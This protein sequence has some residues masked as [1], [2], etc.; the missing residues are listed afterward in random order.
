M[1][2]IQ[3][4]RFMKRLIDELKLTMIVLLAVLLLFSTVQVKPILAYTQNED[5]FEE[6]V[7]AELSTDDDVKINEELL[8]SEDTLNTELL[9]PEQEPGTTEAE[10]SGALESD[11]IEEATPHVSFDENRLE[12]RVGGVAPGFVNVDDLATPNHIAWP[13]N[14]QQRQLQ[15][16]AEFSELGIPKAREI[17]VIVPEGYRILE[18]TAM[19][20]TNAGAGVN[21]LF[22]EAEDNSKFESS[23]LSAIDG[24]SWV[25]QGIDGY[26]GTTAA[27]VNSGIVRERT[28]N[29]QISYVFNSNADHITLTLTLGTHHQVMPRPATDLLLSPIEVTMTSGGQTLRSSLSSTVSPLSVFTLSNVGLQSG[30]RPVSIDEHGNTGIFSTHFTG[31]LH[32]GTLGTQTALTSGVTLTFSYPEGVHFIGFSEMLTH[33]PQ[34]YATTFSNAHL[35]VT[36]DPINRVV[37]FTYS[38]VRTRH[39][40]HSN[41]FVL[42]WEAHV[43]G[44]VLTEGVNHPFGARATSDFRDGSSFTHDF[45]QNVR[46]ELDRSDLQIIPRNFVREDLNRYGDFPYSYMLG[47]FNVNLVGNTPTPPLFYR[48]TFSENLF[49]RAIRTPLNNSQSFSTNIVATTNLRTI[50]VPGPFNN[51][52]RSEDLGLADD[53]FLLAIEADFSPLNIGN[54]NVNAV[55]SQ[56]FIY[57]GRFQNAQ[58]GDVELTFYARGENGAMTQLAT[59]IDRTRIG[60]IDAGGG[61]V[62]TTARH[63]DGSV[64]SFFPSD[65]IDFTSTLTTSYGLQ[66]RTEIV[67]PDIIISLPEGINLDLNSVEALSLAGNHGNNHFPL[68]LRSIQAQEIEGVNWNTF[69]FY[70]PERHDIIGNSTNM[71]GTE[72]ITRNI[73]VYF[74]AHVSPFS[75]IHTGLSAQDIV[76]WNTGYRSS[77]GVIDVHN[78]AGMGHHYRVSAATSSP[79][80]HVVHAPGFFVNMGIRAA[81]SN[82]SFFTFD[83]TNASIAPVAA[84]SNVEIYLQ[85]RN[86]SSTE[87]FAGTG[88][89][90]PIPKRD[91][92]FDSFFN[93]KEVSDP[94]GNPNHTETEWDGTLKSQITLPSFN[95]FYGVGIPA[96]TNAGQIVDRDWVPVTGNWYT[97]TELIAA[98]YTLM[99]VNMVKFIA[100]ENI[101]G[102][103]FASTTFE[104]NV[105][106][107]AAIG[108]VNYWRTYQK[109][110]RDDNATGTWVHGSIVAAEPLSQGISGMIFGDV[111]LNG[112]MAEGMNFDNSELA[113]TAVL[114]ERDQSISPVALTMNPDGSFVSMNADET[115]LLLRSGEYTVTF[116]N[117]SGLAFT[118]VTPPLPSNALQ[119]KM[120][121]EQGNISNNHERATFTFTVGD[122][123]R[124]QMQ[125]IGVGLLLPATV[126]FDANGGA[127]ADGSVSNSV[128]VFAGE[129]LGEPVAPVREGYDFT[130]W[131]LNPADPLSRWSFETAYVLGD[132]TLYARWEPIDATREPE[133]ETETD[134]T[135][136][137]TDETDEGVGNNEEV[138]PNL[139]Q[140]GII[141]S[142]LLI[143]GIIMG[144]LGLSIAAKKKDRK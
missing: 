45:I 27:G 16:Y 5:T 132:M 4:R 10:P 64:G 41:G 56:G 44:E 23:V 67:D 109:G 30:I 1:L 121:I 123:R 29:G 101:L 119:W 125:L 51:F 137:G 31:S 2:E 24:T 112:I 128:D 65:R 78:R 126:I 40:N 76:L 108:Q 94:F 75:P 59:G 7:D 120:D 103:E 13:L 143:G 138:Q 115:P 12:F 113:I 87:L 85:Y 63:S 141:V 26:R 107:D 116:T 37:T 55:M 100:Y 79:E 49:V 74:R 122:T 102:N 3:E 6:M 57:Y 19:Q 86:N 80:I 88:I 92:S 131:Y 133:D 61:T 99:D 77:G 70:P 118:P 105:S 72:V 117:Q 71:G 21:E 144:V 58:E 66:S 130:G 62:L 54:N 33:T 46:F 135:D 22:L 136:N 25:T 34:T 97:Y 52:I 129:R 96:S 106:P 90:L 114:T 69:I 110:W 9:E 42:L 98:G 95:T 28:F 20:G 15:I 91:V 39:I 17:E 104:M 14:I 35:T 47:G 89:Y 93:N 38:N 142:S 83:G 84:G 18:Y 82:G 36:D 48:A 11:Q 111:H 134:V 73:S 124:N 81:N 127:F 50:Q 43:D 32:N 8:D 140:T 68:R 60:F 139:P 53:E